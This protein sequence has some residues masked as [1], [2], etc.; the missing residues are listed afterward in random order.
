[1]GRRNKFQAAATAMANQA[2]REWLESLG[3]DGRICPGTL[4]KPEG[5]RLWCRICQGKT[6]DD[7]RAKGLDDSGQPLP[8]KARPACGAATRA[9]G[10]CLQKIVPCKHRCRFHGG[11]STGPKTAEGRARIS[12]A[13]KARWETI[14][15]KG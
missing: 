6:C 1:M 15:K 5:S 14:K 11:L 10:S 12:A 7:M 9:G 2:H 3:R 8:L 4:H 13:Q